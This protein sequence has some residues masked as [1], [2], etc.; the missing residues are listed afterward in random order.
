MKQIG[1]GAGDHRRPGILVG[2]L[3]AKVGAS[4]RG[5]PSRRNRGHVRQ[6][7]V[8]SERRPAG[9]AQF[10]VFATEPGEQALVTA[11]RLLQDGKLEAAEEAYLESIDAQPDEK[12]TWGEYFQFLRNAG[13]FEEALALSAQAA[14]A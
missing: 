7:G 5:I 2:T 8:H 1:V 13:R 9:C 14:A 10:R 6:V 12:L 11:R 4:W 3:W